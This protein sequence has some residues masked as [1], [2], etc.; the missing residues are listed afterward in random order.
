MKFLLDTNVISELRKGVRANANVV[1]WA[2]GVPL[3]HLSTSVMV[4]GEIRRG[5][6]L[7][8]KTDPGHAASLDEWFNFMRARFSQRVFQ[9]DEVIADK[10]SRL[11]VPNTLPAVDSLLA[12]TALIHD[13]TLVTRNTRDIDK[14]G[15]KL[16]NP[17]LA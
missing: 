9:I 3:N 14:T 8:R 1:R 16:L 6:E 4:L 5:I 11:N 12:A 10:W 13:L 2:A 15:A 7:K 17:F